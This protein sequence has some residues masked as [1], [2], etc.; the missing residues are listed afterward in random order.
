MATY[1][2]DLRLKEI[3]TGDEAGTW[4]TSTNTNLELIGEA[5]GYGTQDCFASDADATT[6]VADGASDPARAMYFKVTSSATLTATRTLTIAPNTVSRVMLIE[7]AT[8]GSQSIAISQGSGGN[9]TIATGQ[10]KMVYLDG[11]GA[12]GAVVDA[13]ADLELGTI[14]VADLTATTADINGGTIDGVTIGGSSAGAITGTTGQFNT[15]LNVDGT[16]TADNAEIGTGGASNANAIIDLTGDTTY[17]D[18]G[19][20]IIRNSGAN[21]RTDLRHRGTGNF[22]IEAVEAAA[23]TFET[24]DTERLRIDSSGNVGIGTSTTTAIRLTATTATANHIGLQVENSNTADSFGM[25]VK[26]GNDANDYTADFRKRDN[27]TIM[28]IRGD[29]NVGVGTSSPSSILHC[30]R[31][32]N[33]NNIILLENADTT[34]AD[35]STQSYFKLSVGGDDIGGLKAA[36]KPLTGLST[37]SL[38]LTTQGNYPIAFG[39]NSSPTPSMVLDT[40]GNLGLGLTP[41]AWSTGKALELGFLGNALWGNAADEVIVSQNAYYNSGWKYATS[42]KATH[43]SQYDAAHRWFTAPSGTADAAISWTQAMTLDSSGNLL[44]GKTALSATTA[45]VELK[46]AGDATFVNTFANGVGENIFLNRQ[47]GTG[48]FVLFRYTNSTVGLIGTDGTTTYVAGASKALKLGATQFIPRTNT[49]GNADNTVDL[50][51]SL[52]RFKDLYLSGGVQLSNGGAVLS[53]SSSAKIS[54]YGGATNRGGQIDFYGGLNTNGVLV[55]RTGAGAGEQPERMRIDSSGNLFVGVTAQQGGGAHCIQAGNGVNSLQMQNNGTN[56]YGPYINFSAATP[57]NAVNY[58]MAC[59]DSTATRAI[60]RSNG[61]L[62][63]YQANDAN[64]SDERVKTDIAPLGSMW[65][66]FKA[67]EIVTFKYKDQSHDDTNIGVIA[68]QVE[69]VAPEFVDNDGFGETP[70]GEEPLK[71]IYTADL[72]HAAIKALQ[73]AMARIETLEAE[74]AALKGA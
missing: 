31:D 57:N 51:A 56:P 50:G 66:K 25:V 17:T 49:D 74:V 28:R 39:I 37:K 21:G 34:T 61:G 1:V 6:T 73:E 44:V 72:Y 55:F 52:H 22:V 53:T 3:A 29:G 69:A 33:A 54:M 40:S 27:T 5:L 45:G 70:E 41:S 32:A 23:I 65:N 71:A 2:N 19:F 12:T 64:L 68:Q 13:L 35:Y 58:F 59:A 14:T 20:R 10:T 67:L 48:N 24:S 43:Y 46:P 18:F 36:N 16:V 47:S 42:R 7:N 9:V 30:K 63:N 4:G 38:F 62:A 26:A 11:A 60:L 15:S 8:T